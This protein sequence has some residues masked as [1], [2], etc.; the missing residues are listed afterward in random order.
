MRES[1]G[2]EPENIEIVTDHEDKVNLDLIIKI[3]SRTLNSGK[4][5]TRTIGKKV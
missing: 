2:K 4:N 5:K 3:C 1:G